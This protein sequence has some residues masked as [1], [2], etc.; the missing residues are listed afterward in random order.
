MKQLV[1]NI[2]FKMMEGLTLV[3]I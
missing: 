3:Y 1:K 2:S